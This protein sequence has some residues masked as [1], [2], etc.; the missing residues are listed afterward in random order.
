MGL[1]P[2][3]VYMRDAKYIINATHCLCKI[4]ETD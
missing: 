2:C 4:V 3:S 1:E